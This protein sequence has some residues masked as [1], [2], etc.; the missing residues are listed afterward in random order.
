[1]G[2]STAPALPTPTFIPERRIHMPL[3]TAASYPAVMQE[4]I[5]HWQSVNATLATLTPDDPVLLQGG[6]AVEDLI[7]DRTNLLTIINSQPGLDNVRSTAAA[8]RDQAKAALIERFFQLKG[9][10]SGVLFGRPILGSIPQAP[11]M[12]MIQSRFLK[13]FYDMKDLWTT[14]NAFASSQD[15]TPPLTLGAYTIATL[16]TD[17]TALELVYINLTKADN[18]AR[19]NRLERDSL[20]KPIRARL[21]QYKNAAIGRLGRTHPLIAS[22][23]VLSPPPGSTPDPVNLS[24]V[25]DS[26][27]LMARLVWTP[28]DNPNLDHYEIRSSPGTRY[29]TAD[30]FVVASA[31]KTE[32]EYLT[33]SGLVAA[34]ASAVFK[35]YVVLYT[36]NERGSNTVKVTRPTT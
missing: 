21:Q 24:G 12:E 6:Y 33:D 19:R 10:L 17:I 36:Q 15:F 25:W 22:I 27:A 4:F 20:L 29:S 23:P 3:T 32:T 2:D 16:D 5:S 35:V 13:P 34:G 18:E 1:M 8:T 30:D 26:T 14:V 11:R 28:S 9:A 31:P 7:A